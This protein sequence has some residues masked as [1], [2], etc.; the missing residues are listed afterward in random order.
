MKFW[1]SS[2]IVRFSVLCYGIYTPGIIEGVA[3]PNNGLRFQSLGEGGPDGG[4]GRVTL[5]ELYVYHTASIPLV[6]RDAAS[7]IGSYSAAL[8][9]P[10]HAV[11][12]PAVYHLQPAA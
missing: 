8:S 11:M 5:E 2:G 7:N 3:G 10:F 6:H 4:V 9:G 1:D 12:C